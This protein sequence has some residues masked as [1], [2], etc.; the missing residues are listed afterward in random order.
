[1]THEGKNKDNFL[2]RNEIEAMMGGSSFSDAFW[3]KM[4]NEFDA[5][6]DQKVLIILGF[7]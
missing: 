2:T 4:M 5:N 1:M 7:V 6:K 3:N